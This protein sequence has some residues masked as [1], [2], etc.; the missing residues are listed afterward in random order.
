MKNYGKNMQLNP[1]Q[2]N[3]KLQVKNLAL[4]GNTPNFTQSKIIFQFEKHCFFRVFE[5]KIT[6]SRGLVIPKTRQGH[7]KP[8][9]LFHLYVKSKYYAGN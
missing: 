5:F 2:Q 9:Y 8:I 3:C 1:F 7:Y 4:S 6:I